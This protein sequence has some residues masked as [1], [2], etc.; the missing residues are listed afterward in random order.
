MD[1][2]QPP[3]R[4]GRIPSLEEETELYRSAMVPRFSW[5]VNLFFSLTFPRIKPDMDH[6]AAV[7]KA[8]SRGLVVYVM[9]SRSVLDYLFFN[10]Y[11]LRYDLPLTR[12]ANGVNMLWW[13]PGSELL[14]GIWKKVQDL[15]RHGPMPDPVDSG[16]MARCLGA[17]YPVLVFLRRQGSWIWQR[18]QQS[19]RDLVEEL[20]EVQQTIDQPIFVVPQ[21]VMWERRPEYTQRNLVDLL[22]GERDH[23]GRLRK[24]LHFGVYH[25]GAIVRTGDPV[26]LGEFLTQLPDLPRPKQA[27]K[28]RLLLR[29]YLYREKRLIKGPTVKPRSWLLDRIHSSPRV[30]ETIRRTAAAERRPV[31]EVSVRAA[32]ALDRIAAD[33]NY[34]WI[35]GA[36]FLFDFVLNRIYAGVEFREDDAERIRRAGRQ[37][38]IVFVPCHRSHLDYILISW[39]VFYQHLLPP[40]VCAGANLGFWPLGPILRRWGA[41][42]IRRSFQDDEL[43]RVLFSTYVRE[44]VREGYP[45]EFFI[46]GTRSR[47]GALLPP[48]VGMLSMYL[49]AAEDKV[50]PDVQFVPISLSYEKVV[51]E[52][53]YHKELTGGDKRPEDLRGLA[54]TPRVLARR[55]GRVYVRVGEPLSARTV[56]EQAGAP[57][58]ELDDLRRKTFLKEVGEQILWEI[59]RVTPVTPSAVAT[60]VLL[61]HHRRGMMVAEFHRRCRFLVDFL[62]A[63]DA[64]FS[65]SMMGET[66]DALDGALR[67]FADNRL[68]EIFEEPDAN[69]I[70]AIVPERRMT[71]DYYKN[72]I[73]NHL[74]GASMMA[75]AAGHGRRCRDDVMQRYAELRDLLHLDLRADPHCPVDAEAEAALAELLEVEALREDGDGFVVE[76]THRA[77]LFRAVLRNLLEAY[78]VTLRGAAVLQLEPMSDR[79]LLEWLQKEGRKLYM[80]EDVTRF[81]AVSKVTLRNAIRTFRAAGVLVTRPDS[82]ALG[83]DTEARQRQLQRVNDLMGDL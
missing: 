71:M 53:E 39:C 82:G 30:Q 3:V 67:Q 20:L 14:G 7:R 72:N 34:D 52:G 44:L 45:Q 69:D 31:H 13:Q 29:G 61:S 23:P 10:W 50:A 73:V 55:Y 74:A 12:F 28:L 43:Y 65:N 35:Q 9:R 2:R 68:V 37:G 38:T 16:F 11:C 19:E 40:H 21:L 47:T 26:D 18:P 63:R 70:I 1:E 79:Q 56:L 62:T 78:L 81:E 58:A 51:E 54:A 59:H 64:C 57:L 36:R 77:A 80:T 42:F 8:A 66:R 22:F 49:D 60:T 24:M 25:R 15:L 83:V 48:K 5:L 41:F 46:E 33:F 6:I 4:M 17:G 75:V 27:K 32:R 76:R